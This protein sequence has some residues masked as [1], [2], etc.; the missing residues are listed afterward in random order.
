MSIDHVARGIAAA[1]RVGGARQGQ[2]QRVLSA[3]QS[4]AAG[5]I[6][7]R[8]VMSSP[9]TVTA[10]GATAPAALTNGYTYAAK[11]AA[12]RVVGGVPIASASKYRIRSAIIA[13][14]GGNLAQGD[15][16]TGSYGRWEFVADAA[17][18]AVRVG[19]QSLPYRFIVDGQYVDATGTTTLVSTGSTDEYISLDFG[20]R[21]TRTIAVE[22]QAALGF[23]GAYV[24]AT[25]S[26][27]PSKAANCR[28]IWLGDSYS[29]GSSATALGDGTAAQLGDYLG[30]EDMWASGSSGTGW[31]TANSSYRFD[32]RVTADL[33]AH[34]PDIVFLQG[35]YNDRNGLTAT[36]EA[37]CLSALRTIRT[38]LPYVPIIVFGA[39][40]GATG[41]SAGVLAAEGAVQDAVTA[42]N[43]DLC[44]FIPVSSIAS[45]ALISGT[46]KVGTTT[47]TGNSDIYTAADGVH[48]PTAGCSYIARYLASQVPPAL[49]AMI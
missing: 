33:I 48:P 21:A 37:N 16:S 43:D 24:G 35:S 3:Y 26:V 2:I 38:A 34:E 46:G 42:F 40:A 13:A 32:E 49:M 12:F 29:Y 17:K 7:T 8:G 47:G 23:V 5:N 25:E 1:A 22:T 39:F 18:V 20:S 31:S 4:A 30:I 27:L 44:A 45:G 36:I 14:T 41:P 11:P 10:E 6:R 19:P 9:P 28:G 15:G